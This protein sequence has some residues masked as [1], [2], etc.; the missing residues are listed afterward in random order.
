MYIQNND[1]KDGFK[2]SLKY[3]EVRHM[4]KSWKHT[5]GLFV[6]PK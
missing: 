3:V 1:N 6:S 2:K 4:K 5:N